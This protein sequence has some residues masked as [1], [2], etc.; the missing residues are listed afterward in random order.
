[1]NITTLIDGL[2]L[3]LVCGSLQTEISCIVDD[4]RLAEPGCLFI[5]RQ[6]TQ[7]DGAQYIADAIANGAVAVVAIDDAIVPANIARI[8]SDD[9]NQITASLSDRF[10]ASPCKSS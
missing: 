5:A 10:Y 9:P 8:I 7:T 6:G 1:M 3:E 2:P 4:S